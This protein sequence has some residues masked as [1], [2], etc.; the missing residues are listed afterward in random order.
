MFFEKVSLT[1]W[2]PVSNV[3]E[4]CL[5]TEMIPV[6]NVGESGIIS[7]SSEFWS[8]SLFSNILAHPCKEVGE[9]EQHK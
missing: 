8:D 5:M 3:V 6:P 4:S 1:E 7:D 9:D 2:I